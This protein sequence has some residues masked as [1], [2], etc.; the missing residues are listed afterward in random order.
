MMAIDGADAEGHLRDNLCLKHGIKP[1]REFQL[2]G[3]L[4]K[5]TLKVVS[6]AV[7]RVIDV[8][9]NRRDELPLRDEIRTIIDEHMSKFVLALDRMEGVV[10]NKV[11]T[12][13]R[14]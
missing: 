10:L 14:H 5:L 9:T 7:D 1:H 6:E 12:T 8:W 3:V 13:G 4:E 11:R 2:L